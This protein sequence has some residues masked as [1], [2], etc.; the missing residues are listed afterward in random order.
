[1][2]WTSN[3]WLSVA[4]VSSMDLF[5]ERQITFWVFGMINFLAIVLLNYN[6]S[7]QEYNGKNQ[8]CI[9]KVNQFKKLNKKDAKNYKNNKI[10]LN[11]K[12]LLVTT[13]LSQMGLIKLARIKKIKDKWKKKVW[14]Y[15]TFKLIISRNMVCFLLVKRVKKYTNLGKKE[16]F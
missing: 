1:M 11:I 16:L 5:M 10:N 3:Y 7:H 15:L 14:I 9:L 13:N 8:S 4:S 12:K 6:I 2:L